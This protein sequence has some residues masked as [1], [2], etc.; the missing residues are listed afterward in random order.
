MSAIKFNLGIF[1]YEMLDSVD[2]LWGTKEYPPHKN[3]FSKLNNS[4]V[5]YSDWLHGLKSWNLYKCN[6]MVDYTTFYCLL[7]NFRN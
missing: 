2:T 7:G 1:P 4:N 6:D 3:F 5:S